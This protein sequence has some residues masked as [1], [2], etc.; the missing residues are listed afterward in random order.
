[1][2][3][4]Y[5]LISSNVLSS[6]AASVTFSAIPSTYTDLVI[7]WS[8]N[9][10]STLDGALYFNGTLGTTNYS[11][12]ALSGN[13]ASATSTR[14]SDREYID[15]D[16]IGSAA[17]NTFASGEMYLPNYA[18]SNNKPLS[19]VSA[20]EANSTTAYLRNNA[21]LA[22]V[23]AA[24]TSITISVPVTFSAGSSFYLYGIK[25]S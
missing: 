10:S 12:T 5:T 2:P 11:R 22:R 13:G 17:A 9:T 18:G 25:N 3:S 15:L 24:V 7:R 6:S 8:V 23:T 20:L 1:M 14:N 4:T 19:T 16:Y 21:G